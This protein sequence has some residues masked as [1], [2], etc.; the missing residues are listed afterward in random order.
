MWA[1][2][3]REVIKSF[4]EIPFCKM[5]I[6]FLVAD[7]I[8]RRRRL[9]RRSF[10]TSKT[11]FVCDLAAMPVAAAELDIIILQSEH[12]R[13]GNSRISGF[14]ATHSQS[15][16]RSCVD[17]IFANLPKQNIRSGTR[18]SSFSYT[19]THALSLTYKHIHCNLKEG[20]RVVGD[21]RT[22]EWLCYLAL[23]SKSLRIWQSVQ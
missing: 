9:W 18:N 5:L 21:G 22:I 13:A 19:T 10:G 1:V 17:I 14:M 3:G 4:A 2:A 15:L 20:G 8:S 6:I 12:L 23:C 7:F 16:S 11:D